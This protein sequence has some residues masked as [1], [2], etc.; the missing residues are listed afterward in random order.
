MEIICNVLQCTLKITFFNKS[1]LNFSCCI[2][3]SLPAVPFSMEINNCK[4]SKTVF[5]I[6][7]KI[8]LK[9]LKVNRVRF[10]YLSSHQYCRSPFM[11]SILPNYLKKK[12]KERNCLLLGNP[13]LSLN[14]HRSLK[15]STPKEKDTS[16]FSFCLRKHPRRFY[17]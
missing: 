12:K 16:Q 14:L 15:G 2:F 10:F 9:F 13:V 4:L 17:L 7:K 6:L 11:S 8:C 5:H 3:K 1:N